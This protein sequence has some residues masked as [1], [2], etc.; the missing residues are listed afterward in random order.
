MLKVA[1][2]I[3]QYIGI[4]INKVG[5][6]SNIKKVWALLLISMVANHMLRSCE[7]NQVFRV[8]ITS[9]LK[10]LTMLTNSLIRSNNHFH[11]TREHWILSYH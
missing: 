3:K 2:V 8:K 4:I 6:F 11:S 10:L 5:P 7:E 9:N 1:V